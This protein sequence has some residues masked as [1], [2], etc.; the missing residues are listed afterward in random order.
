MWLLN[1]NLK[2][3]NA[4]EQK[5]LETSSAKHRRSPSVLDLHIEVP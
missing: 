4:A 5:L 3:A 2:C 1:Y